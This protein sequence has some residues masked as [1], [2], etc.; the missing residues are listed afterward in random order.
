[1]ATDSFR[2]FDVM[3]TTPERVYQAWLNSAE[4]T[5]MTG[6]KATIDPATGAFTAWDGY[7]R[8]TTLEADPSRRI[9]QS[10]RSEE[11][12]EGSGD[13]RI[14]LILEVAEGGTMLTLIHTDIPEGQGAAYQQGWH[15]HY[16]VPMKSYFVAS[17]APAAPANKPA[18]VASAEQAP[19]PKQAAA[20]PAPREAAKKPAAR[21]A[22]RK[23]AKKPAA[24][25]AA[26]KPAPRKAAKKPAARKAARKPAAKV[27]KKP[28]R[29]SAAK[30]PAA[31]KAT[32]KPAPRKTTAGKS[33]R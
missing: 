12:P 14:E 10:W 8:G 28:A 23:A 29:K 25:K 3:P 19:A 33:R 20:K 6:G 5:S 1:M 7:I 9:V 22:A 15:D 30:K 27:A 18:R 24:R 4:H 32:K 11:F 13:S 16:F 26:R 21:K 17:S 31:R 2:V